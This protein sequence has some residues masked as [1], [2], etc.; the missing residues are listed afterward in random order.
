MCNDEQ[1]RKNLMWQEVVHRQARNLRGGRSQVRIAPYWTLE[2]V[3]QKSKG[4]PQ[5]LAVLLWMQQAH[6]AAAVIPTA[7]HFNVSHLPLTAP[8]LSLHPYLHLS[9]QPPLSDKCNALD[10]IRGILFTMHGQAS[11]KSQTSNRLHSTA[12]HKYTAAIGC[13]SPNVTCTFASLQAW[14]QG[15]SKFRVSGE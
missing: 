10:T 14:N 11:S 2:C 7:N 15:F 4:M 5:P 9:L 1:R 6:A 3:L 12:A 8:S 13:L